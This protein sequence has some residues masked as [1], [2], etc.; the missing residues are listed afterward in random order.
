M[1][2]R[3]KVRSV[4]FDLHPSA[5]P[6]ALLAAPEFAVHKRLIHRQPSWQP[7]KKRNQG[8][9]MRFSGSKI[10]QHVEQAL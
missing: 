1:H 4:G 5:A 6:K 10:A 9:A 3:K 8:L 2:T 7:R